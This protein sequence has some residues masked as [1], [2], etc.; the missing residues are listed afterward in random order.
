MRGHRQAVN[1]QRHR[2]NGTAAAGQSQRKADQE[3]E[4]QAYHVRILSL[5][6]LIT[7][8]PELHRHIRRTLAAQ[9]ITGYGEIHLARIRQI[10]SVHDGDKGFQRRLILQARIAGFFLG[11]GGNKA[12]LV[13]MAGIDQSFIRQGEQ[14]VMDAAIQGGGVPALKIGAPASVNEQRIPGKQQQMSSIVHPV[15]MVSRSMSGRKQRPQLD[16]AEVKAL[17]LAQ[18]D[19][20]AG[21][22]IHRRPADLASGQA[23]ELERAAQM[24]GM[25]MR[26]QGIAQG[27]PQALQHLQIPLGSVNHR[28]NDRARAGVRTGQQI[29]VGTGYG[30]KKLSENHVAPLA[31]RSGRDRQKQRIFPD[32]LVS[33]FFHPVA[34]G[35]FHAAESRS[36]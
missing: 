20:G 17:T 27:Q 29:A 28:I 7:G 22:L 19:V 6:M 36:H 13:I 5:F 33:R 8:R 23:L 25:N 31:L 34:G 11:N 26:V 3:A 15:A 35:K 9:P 1:Q 14:L 12:A 4:Q 18:A 32:A 24:I 16:M 2:E 30:F 10:K 21:Q